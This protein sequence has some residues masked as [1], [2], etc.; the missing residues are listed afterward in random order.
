MHILAVGS[1]PESP[2]PYSDLHASLVKTNGFLARF[3]IK[4]QRK[5]L[6]M[7]GKNWRQFFCFKILLGVSPSI[8]SR[9]K[10]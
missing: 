10:S 5:I 1:P 3:I 8:V 2:P 4:R 6:G 9:L 7:D